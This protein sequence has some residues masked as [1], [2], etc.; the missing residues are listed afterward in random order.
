MWESKIMLRK[1]KLQ[2]YMFVWYIFGNQ[3]VMSILY[4]VDLQYILFNELQY[5]KHWK[6]MM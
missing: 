6:R 1:Y 5:Y 2:K 4:H 3:H